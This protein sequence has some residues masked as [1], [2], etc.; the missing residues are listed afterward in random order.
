MFITQIFSAQNL[1]PNPSFEDTVSCP[2][3]ISDMAACKYWFNPLS[4]STSDYFNACYPSTL[5]LSVNVPN[6]FPGYQL[7]RTGNAYCGFTMA[8]PSSLYPFIYAEYIS[9]QIDT[10][11]IIGQAYEFKMYLNL[12]DFS[13]YYTNSIGV[14]FTNN[15]YIPSSLSNTGISATP[16]LMNVTNNF[17]SD[18]VNWI[19]FKQTFK[20]DSSYQFLTIG[21]F[22][23]YSNTTLITTGLTTG[24]SYPYFYID[25]VS[26]NPVAA[27]FDTICMGDSLSL[28]SQGGSLFSWANSLNPNVIISTDSIF[29]VSP[30]I[31]TTYYDYSNNDTINHVVSVTT[32]QVLNLG[33]DTNLCPSDTLILN[34]NNSYSTY[35]WQDSTTDYK[36]EVT[37]AGTYWVQ[38]TNS[39]GV[40]TDTINVTYNTM[41]VNLG[42]DTSLCNGGYLILNP[43]IQN[44]NYLWQ[45]NSTNPSYYVPWQQTPNYFHVTVRDSNTCGRDT[46]HIDYI[47]P[48]LNSFLGNDTFLCQGQQINI[49]YN[50]PLAD[51]YIWSNGSTDSIITINSPGQYWLELSNKCYT[52]S[53]TINVTVKPTPYF[54]LGNDL[55][56][57]NNEELVLGVNTIPNAVVW[58]NTTYTP[59]ITIEKEGQY[60]ATAAYQGCYFKDTINVAYEDCEISLTIPNV[61]TPNADGMNDFLSLEGLNINSINIKILN[62][63]GQLVFE[64]NDINDSWN[65]KTTENKECPSGTYFYII[66][67]E[68]EQ[69]SKIFKGTI[70]LL[71]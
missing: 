67:A 58:W 11:L 43:N 46:I 35:L 39:C 18:T 5:G 30:T 60:I 38:V 4:N 47:P 14:L 65:G 42:N 49:L 9:V 17:I 12:A 31:N 57:C 15:T 61:F 69:S 68:N 10:Q 29:I 21:N 32:N 6:N 56:L 51:N 28:I 27:T 70:T 7:A 45:N 53:D 36:Y 41:P 25:D 26:L 19:E 3:G 22:Q 8:L 2:I 63:W 48:F 59:T 40:F 16:Q 23:D 52:K 50:S 37:Q 20:A 66:T 13:E 62:R 24:H 64:S 33:N 1:I 55:T 71:R 44:A 34:A 54:E